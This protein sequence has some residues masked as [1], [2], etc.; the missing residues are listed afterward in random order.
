MRLL[1]RRNEWL[2]EKLV[3][4]KITAGRHE[5]LWEAGHLPTGLYFCRMQTGGQTLAQKMTLLR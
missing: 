3:D 4:S 5:A 2:V 1:R